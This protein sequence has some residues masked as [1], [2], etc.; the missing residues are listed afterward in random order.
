[1]IA[2]DEEA[3]IGR[4]LSS[5]KDI[6]DEIIVVDTGSTDST[7]SIAESFG[8]IVLDHPWEDDFSA[9]RNTGLEA[10]TGDWIM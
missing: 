9:P 1:M 5:V 8:A 7:K 2:K 10:A 4:A 3:S 6:C